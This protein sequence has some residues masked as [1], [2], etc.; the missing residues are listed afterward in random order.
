[1]IMDL[2]EPLNEIAQKHSKKPLVLFC[3]K[4]IHED[5]CW[6]VYTDIAEKCKDFKPSEQ[7][8]D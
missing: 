5:V 6:K 8:V 7:G 2:R 4:C 3:D 1:M